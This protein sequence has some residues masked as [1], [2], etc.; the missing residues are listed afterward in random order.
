MF[1]KLNSRVFFLLPEFDMTIY[2]GWYDKVCSEIPQHKCE[3]MRTDLTYGL[4][5]P[6]CQERN[7]VNHFQNWTFVP[8][9]KTC[10]LVSEFV[11]V[12]V[13]APYEHRNP[14]HGMM[15]Y[16]TNSLVSDRLDANSGRV[17]VGHGDV[18]DDVPVHVARLVALWA[19]KIVKVHMLEFQNWKRKICASS[20]RRDCGNIPR[21]HRDKFKTETNCFRLFLVNANQTL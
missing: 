1:H 2:A 15:Q 4:L 8:W 7:S 3:R 6:F 17:L 12:G 14:R 5:A 10:S 19:G 9:G 18:A 16:D 21:N 20:L 11:F 13:S